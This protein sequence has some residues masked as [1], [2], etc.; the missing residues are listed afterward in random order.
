MPAPRRVASCGYQTALT[1]ILKTDPNDYFSTL[2]ASQGTLVFIEN[3][4]N[5]P[6]LDSS[7]RVINPA[8]EVMIALSPESTYSTPGIR[9]FHP[10]KRKCYYKDEVHIGDFVH[11]SFHNCKSLQKIESIETN[12]ECTPFY[13]PI[14][15][16]MRPCNFYDMNCIRQVADNQTEEVG[17]SIQNSI[18]CLPECEHFDYPLETAFGEMSNNVPLGGLTFFENIDLENK[19]VLNVFFNDLV[20]TRYRRDVNFN[21]Q[22]LLAAFGGLLSLM[23]GF[24]LISGFDFF[25]FLISCIVYDCKITNV[26]TNRTEPK[27]VI[28]I[29]E[30]RNWPNKL[31]SKRY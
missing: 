1:V 22:N 14:K 19:S 20:S 17:L 29:E 24:T 8:E 31:Y 11:Y 4:Y 12:C 13:F 26:S 3:A 9:T 28:N 2:T 30:K 5:H 10:D 23:L 27:N 18:E 7:L 15:E 21:W 25:I 16:K 6:D